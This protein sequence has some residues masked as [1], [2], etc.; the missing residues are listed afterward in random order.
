MKN[1]KAIIAAIICIV[2]AIAGI[3]IGMAVT[4]KFSQFTKGE[5]TETSVTAQEETSS[6]PANTRPKTPTPDSVVASVYDSYS[7]KSSQDL[8][9]F[10]NFGFNTV[11]FELTPE[12][13][14]T[15]APLFTAANELQLYFGVR[16]DISEKSD[17]L[18]EFVKKY[19]TD[20]VILSGL[21][22]SQVTYSENITKICDS[23]KS[24]DA[25]MSIGIE[26]L[27]F[28][29]AESSIISLMGK[30][31]DFV[32]LKQKANDRAGNKAFAQAQLTWSE[33]PAPVWLCHT[34]LGISSFNAEK[35]TEMI[36][37]I[38]SS[39]DMA[40]CKGLAFYPY[41][42]ISA[43][44]GAA[45]ESVMS[46]IKSR[47][48]YLLD[49]EFEITNH[50]STKITVEQS[51]V[52]FRGSSSP[53]YD[54]ICNGQKLNVAKNGDFSV[55]CEL[56]AGANTIKFEHKGKT[57][58]YEVT[59]KIKLL[60]SVSPADDSTVPGGMQVEIGAVAL[61][62]A[63]VTV[64]FNGKTVTMTQLGSVSQDEDTSPDTESD[65]AD[66]TATVT[67]PAGTSSVQKLGK[68]TVKAVYGSLTETMSGGNINVSA[69][70]QPP[71]PAPTPTTTTTKPTTITSPST[72]ESTG[73]GNDST[74]I[75]TS[76]GYTGE[77]LERYY[78]TKD[79][80]LGTAKI[81][82]IIENYVEVYPGNSTATYSV[83]DC[84]PLPKTTV[85]YVTD[86]AVLDETDTYY[87][88][89]SG[90]KVPELHEER[91]ASGVQGKITH[92]RISDGYVMPKNSINVISTS[93][94]DKE[95]VIVLDMNRPVAFNAKLTGQTYGLYAPGRPVTVT[96]LNCTGI[97][98]VFSD[99]ANAS[100][101]STF[102]NSPV[103]SGK[104][105]SD[106]SKST[107]TLSLTLADKGKFYGYHYEY[108]N[109]GM[110]VIT[111]SHKP[112]SLSGAVI[113]LDPGHG[114]I[115]P[116]APCSV[117]I[118]GF[119]NE[120]DINLSIASKVKDLLETEGAT[121]I[122]TRNGDDW[123]SYTQRNTAVRDYDPDMFISIHCDSSTSASATGTSAYY[124]RAYSQPLAKSI[125]DSLVN[126]YK[127]EIYKDKTDIKIDRGTNFYA[128]N[129][130][131]VEE[132]PAVLIEYG[133]VSNTDECQ[134]L[135]SAENRE[136]LAK[137]T[138]EGIKKYLAAS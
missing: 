115:D 82:E 94:S 71:P 121:V 69:K 102:M 122:M 40:L 84:S 26:P 132:C 81:C 49:K 95:T 76:G 29:L 16:A 80:G 38:S 68:F 61:K 11:I 6:L 47:D 62:G 127:N 30:K 124:Y 22:E 13:A 100:G 7:D 90:V 93:C 106:K 101:S 109:D 92:V 136:I 130:V 116:G 54:L 5:N 43:A 114:G 131:R 56:K 135:Q 23:I 24:V 66:Y 2:V 53:A 44:S 86:I 33:E 32:F 123:K 72:N 77:K 125:H 112:K 74:T 83:P 79:Y 46:Y 65:F 113:M 34:L 18:L 45:A 133:F 103:K 105:S 21:D 67:V 3:I 78:Y 85:D 39:A 4:G 117:N 1:N 55:D 126:A 17:Y 15:V 27:K 128:F 48:T 19:N 129:V 58:T 107:V 51:K 57:Y 31:A 75:I 10:V 28:E 88:L 52:T 42:D 111:L 91:L 119:S 8:A 41:S 87:F 70:V 89:A 37:L 98:F 14:E 97:D 108:N 73:V 36:S 138:V 120:K 96:S 20:F 35:A 9:K 118:T 63:T 99:T 134:S 12:N 137:A 104:W 60:K 59:Y 25:A 64:T 50:K 110:L